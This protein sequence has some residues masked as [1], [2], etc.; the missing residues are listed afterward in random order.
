[1]WKKIKNNKLIK[2]PLGEVSSSVLLFVRWWLHWETSSGDERSCPFPPVISWSSQQLCL[3]PFRQSVVT[4]CHQ[5]VST[6]LGSKCRFFFI[7]NTLTESLQGDHHQCSRE[8]LTVKKNIAGTP[9]GWGNFQRRKLP[10]LVWW[11]C[12]GKGFGLFFALFL[13]LERPFQKDHSSS[14]QW[15]TAD[16]N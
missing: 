8:L 16:W 6:A 15:G 5:T 4:L 14:P 3:L 10:T 11:W 9:G 12:Q 13:F 1:M 2:W 7:R